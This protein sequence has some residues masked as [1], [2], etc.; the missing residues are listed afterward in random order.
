MGRQAGEL[1]HSMMSFCSKECIQK[2][3]KVCAY[4]RNLNRFAHEE[5]VAKLWAEIL[6][7]DRVGVPD[8]FFELGGHSLLAT[9]VASRMRQALGV[10]L[11]LPALFEAPTVVEPVFS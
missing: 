10:E 6:G 1:C 11:P 8:D 9:Q 2:R 5:I 3:L 7:L 4:R